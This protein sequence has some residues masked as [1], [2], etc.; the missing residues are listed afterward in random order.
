LA[1]APQATTLLAFADPRGGSWGVALTAAEP[2]LLVGSAEPGQDPEPAAAAE[3]EVGDELAAGWSIR[4]AG[5]TFSALPDGAVAR[6]V[7]SRDDGPELFTLQ[8][9]MTGGA[10][11]FPLPESRFDSLRLLAAW[12]PG[13][14]AVALATTRP[15]GVKGHDRDAIS[16]AVCGEDATLHIFDPRLSSTYNGDGSLRRAGAEMWL[17]E[18]EEGDLFP[19]R[20]AGEVSGPPGRLTAAGLAVTAYPLGCHWRGEDGTGVYVLVRPA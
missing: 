20:V 8:G 14:G 13:G 2:A 12:V 3:L 19:R 5:R 9:D 6:A 16:A 4:G 15:V 7:G 11:G 1:P 18:S 17:G 10:A